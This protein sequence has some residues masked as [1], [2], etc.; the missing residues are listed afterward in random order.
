MASCS[1]AA[2]RCRSRSATSIDPFAL[3]DAYGVDQLRYFFLREVPFGQDGNYSHEAIVN[4]INADLAND[5]GN[6]A[7]RSLSM[8][9]KNLR[10]R[11]A[12][13]PAIF[14]QAD[15]RSALARATR[16]RR[17]RRAAMQDFALHTVLA[18]IWARRRG[19]EPL[20]RG[21]GAVGAAQDRSGADG[22]GALRH[23]G[24]AARDRHPGAALYAGAAAKLLDLLGCRRPSATLRPC[25]RRGIACGRTRRCRRPRRSSRAMSSRRAASLS[26]SKRT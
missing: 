5:L 21:A 16:C 20:F 24:G 17:R 1:T 26:S 13:S 7:Q 3:A 19:G 6:L 8:I 22:D 12:G 2:R 25:R 14:T 15:Q 9:A 11:R 10:R 18:E 23:G 4:R